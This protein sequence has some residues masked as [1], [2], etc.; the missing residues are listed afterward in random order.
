MPGRLIVFEGVEGA[1]KTTQLQRLCRRLDRIGIE[2]SPFREPGG[3]VL[4]DEIRSLLLQPGNAVAPSSEALLFMASRAQLIEE[5]VRPALA[6]GHVVLLDRFFLS[7]YAY[8][9]VGRRL[10]EDGVRAANALAVGDLVPDVTILL[11]LSVSEGMAR[12]GRRGARDRMESEP[13]LFHVRV[14]GAFAAFDD[15]AWQ[16]SH[17]EAGPIVAI[18]A[19]GE[20]DGVEERVWQA[21]AAACPE[22]QG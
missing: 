8:Q 2:N 18:D 1:G 11:M 10:E 22:V 20:P 17:P 15:P 14:E 6:R 5:R 9:V 3:T 12:V 21:V 13:E 7:T 4:G 16:K 19:S